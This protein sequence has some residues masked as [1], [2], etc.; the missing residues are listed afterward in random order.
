MEYRIKEKHGG[1]GFVCFVV[2]FSCGVSCVSVVSCGLS[3][4]SVVSCRVSVVYCLLSKIY[5]LLDYEFYTTYHEVKLIKLS[6][7]SCE[8]I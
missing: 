4:V 5:L 8:L 6:C 7:A 2:L 1:P 3:C